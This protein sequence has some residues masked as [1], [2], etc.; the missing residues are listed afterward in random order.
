M[1]L[2]HLLIPILLIM[3]V[4]VST[5][6]KHNYDNPPSQNEGIIYYQDFDFNSFKYGL[7]SAV[8]GTV[9]VKGN[10]QNRSDRHLQIVAHIQI[11]QRDNSGVGFSIKGWVPINIISSYPEG[12]SKPESEIVIENGGGVLQDIDIGSYD[13]AKRREGKTAWGYGKQ[14]TKGDIIIN[15]DPATGVKLG[16]NVSL[17]VG[18]GKPTNPGVSSFIPDKSGKIIQV[19]DMHTEQDVIH[20]LI[21]L[22]VDYRT[23]ASA[24]PSISSPSSTP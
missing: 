9:F 1:P 22:N 19:P 12:Y 7:N 21:P 8:Q 6:C 4:L 24:T 18:V 23:N 17:V 11:D 2:P 3:L 20:F 15:L 13:D 10:F 16:D 5:S 14:D